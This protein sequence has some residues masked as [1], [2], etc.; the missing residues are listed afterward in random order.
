MEAAAADDDAED[1]QLLTM[2]E[3]QADAAPLDEAVSPVAGR[4]FSRR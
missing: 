1:L 2:L 4:R 3:P